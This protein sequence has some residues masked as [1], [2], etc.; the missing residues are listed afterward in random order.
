MKG[1]NSEGSVM[2]ARLPISIMF[3]PFLNT[4]EIE[5]AAAHYRF[6]YSSPGG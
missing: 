1:I 2:L 5:L 6:D 4:T 3:T